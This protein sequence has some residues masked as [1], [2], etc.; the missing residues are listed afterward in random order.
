MTTPLLVPPGD[1]SPEAH[2]KAGHPPKP[3]TIPELSRPGQKPE[4]RD[5][6]MYPHERPVPDRRDSKHPKVSQ[7]KVEGLPKGTPVL[8]PPKERKVTDPT[9]G[10]RIT[11]L[12]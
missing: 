4:H 6:P 12:K 1:A 3:A 9:A 8:T 10:R 5:D 11:Y 2:V 7:V